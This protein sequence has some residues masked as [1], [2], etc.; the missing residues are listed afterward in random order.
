ML[1]FII[2]LILAYLAFGLGGVLILAFVI[3]AGYVLFNAA[4]YYMLKRRMRF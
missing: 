1:L 3:P 2:V 4:L